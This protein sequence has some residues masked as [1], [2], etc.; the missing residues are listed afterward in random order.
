M[1]F[2][3]MFLVMVA[4]MAPAVGFAQE[5]GVD[6]GVSDAGIMDSGIMDSAVDAG[7][8]APV[9][10]PEEGGAL[11]QAVFEAARGGE[12]SLFVSLLIMLLV[13]GATKVP[14]ISKFV[15]G[16]AKIWVAAVAG[17]LAAFATALYL[18]VNDGVEGVNWL[19]V[20]MRGL[21]AGLAAGG[22]WS[23]LGPGSWG[24][25]LMRMVTVN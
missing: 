21:S 8:S 24:S 7:A 14:F 15:K 19:E 25:P 23:L 9:A 10:M 4:V 12:W 17:V 22:L 2:T 18:D 3:R 6:A 20:A 13:F 16:Q 11:V 1:K 5:A